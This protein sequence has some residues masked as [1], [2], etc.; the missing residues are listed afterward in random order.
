[1]GWNMKKIHYKELLNHN[2]VVSQYLLYIAMFSMLISLILF[3][4][5]KSLVFFIGIM[6]IVCAFLV[7]YN[8]VVLTREMSKNKRNISF[9][10]RVIDQYPCLLVEGDVGN[11]YREK[12]R[13]II[14]NR[15]K[16]VWKPDFVFE[17]ETNVY[18]VKD[19][20]VYIVEGY[21]NDL[22]EKES[23][24]VPYIIM[25]NDG[26]Y[27]MNWI[28]NVMCCDRDWYFAYNFTRKTLKIKKYQNSYY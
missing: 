15:I 2:M 9:Y 10:N 13:D 6:S 24:K 19:S 14:C 16:L 4:N 5:S 23:I 22:T 11:T 7:I 12:S 1:M 26:A 20:N 27:T 17:E 18:N 21:F 3:I 8:I 28:D 25:F